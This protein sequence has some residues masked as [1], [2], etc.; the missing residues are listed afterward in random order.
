MARHTPAHNAVER[1]L[2]NQLQYTTMDSFIKGVMDLK[3]GL[4][5]KRWCRPDNVMWPQGSKQ[6]IVILLEWKLWAD[7]EGNV[8]GSRVFS[9]VV[10]ER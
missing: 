8:I 4:V 3:Q 2:Y 9:V 7:D 6:I 5:D 10:D 1:T